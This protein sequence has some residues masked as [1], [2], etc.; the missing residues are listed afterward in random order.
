MRT[1][2]FDL[3]LKRPATKRRMTRRLPKDD[4]LIPNIN[5]G[6]VVKFDEN[7]TIIE[8]FGDLGGKQ[9]PMV[10]PMREHKGYLYIGGILNNRIGKYKLVNADQ[11]WTGMSSYWGDVI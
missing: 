6:G 7:G 5:T 1:P 11:Q 10:T 2:T 8:V 9:H 3:M 4:W